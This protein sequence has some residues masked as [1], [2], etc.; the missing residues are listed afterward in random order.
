MFCCFLL[1]AGLTSIPQ[2]KK[3]KIA[4]TPEC[5]VKARQGFLKYFQPKDSEEL[6]MYITLTPEP[7]LNIPDSNDLNQILEWQW[8]KTNNLYFVQYPVDLDI[9][10][11]GLTSSVGREDKLTL[12]VNDP[13]AC[14][15]V[16]EL[17]NLVADLIWRD[18]LYNDSDSYLCNR[19]T[20]KDDA[21]KNIV[22]Y[23]SMIWVGYDLTCSY[24]QEK[25][26]VLSEKES[27]PTII[28]YICFIIAL[29]YPLIFKLLNLKSIITKL[30]IDYPR[31]KK[32]GRKYLTSYQKG[33]IP[34]GFQRFVLK[35]F[36]QI[37]Y[38]PCK[39]EED[40]GYSW[41]ILQ[42]IAS[43]RL[44]TVLFIVLC[45]M[46][47]YRYHFGM[48]SSHLY[49]STTEYPD[50][51]RVG[52]P[53]QYFRENFIELDIF[54]YFLLLVIGH[55]L[56][57]VSYVTMCGT[58]KIANGAFLQK[59]RVRPIL[60]FIKLSDQFSHL[61]TMR[62]I[63]RFIAFTSL[64]FWSK[65]WNDVKRNLSNCKILF[66]LFLIPTIIFYFLTCCFPVFWLVFYGSLELTQT[67]FPWRNKK[68]DI[69]CTVCTWIY[70]L[71]LFILCFS[72][73][74]L[75]QWVIL[76]SITYLLRTFAYILFV[77]FTANVRYMRI[78]LVIFTTIGYMFSFF[79]SS[80][81]D[82]KDMLDFIFKMKEEIADEKI[83][84]GHSASSSE[85][86]NS[87]FTVLQDGKQIIEADIVYED[88]FDKIIEKF[89]NVRQKVFWTV[90][91]VIVSFGFLVVAT[92]MLLLNNNIENN[93]SDSFFKL[94]FIVISP[95][96]LFDYIIQSNEKHIEEH[97][98]SIKQT[99]SENRIEKHEKD[100]SLC[101]SFCIVLDYC[102]ACGRNTAEEAC[103]CCCCKES[104]EEETNDSEIIV[105]D[106]DKLFSAFICPIPITYCCCKC[107]CKID[108]ETTDIST[109]EIL[110]QRG[111]N[112]ATTEI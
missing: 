91:K 47:T 24:F 93:A 80:V 40:V 25:T 76:C 102:C 32:I 38:V 23:F 33:D 97:A 96:I 19:N 106:D 83:R 6:L 7:K 51:Y 98:E 3:C 70:K 44:V 36:Y 82:Y 103:C 57:K 56:L 81:K 112:E 99:L 85:T 74:L 15:D 49:G 94:A 63:D 110:Y 67:A 58:K 107:T 53:V 28:T 95:K 20:D 50:V 11:F 54:L 90:F 52:L 48:H 86:I 46:S 18:I 41:S 64:R 69:C 26:K 73:M 5:K 78:L 17:T 66:F 71:L 21:A 16:K 39:D 87:I 14:T 35:I 27:G 31:G 29:F 105:K 68:R 42:N 8:V 92:R 84:T 111:N 45:A 72:V 55:M 30:K 34:F 59:Y 77:A 4:L 13:D 9:L 22:F 101:T 88:E 104:I 108:K 43:C 60:H 100:K 79:Q 65:L 75:S 1:F 10:T 89:S 62:F 109:E 2:P 37:K 61:F 12:L